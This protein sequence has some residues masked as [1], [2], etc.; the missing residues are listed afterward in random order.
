MRQVS[1]MLSN[2]AWPF[3]NMFF[4]IISNYMPD[5]YNYLVFLVMIPIFSC[6][7]I[8]L[9]FVVETPIFLLVHKENYKKYEEVIEEI[10]LYN[11]ADITEIKKDL[12]MLRKCQ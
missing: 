11:D 8:M 5:W 6:W 4:V 10:A 12:M 2:A 7:A 3:A 1:L 9:F